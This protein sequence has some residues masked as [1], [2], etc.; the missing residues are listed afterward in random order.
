MTEMFEKRQQLPSNGQC[1]YAPAR[2]LK[3][4][5]VRLATLPSRTRQ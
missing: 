5:V 3:L 4:R 2:E 1:H